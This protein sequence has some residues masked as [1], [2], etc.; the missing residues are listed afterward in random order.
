[1]DIDFVG[2]FEKILF[3][4][5][6]AGFMGA[7]VSV[8]W[9]KP[10]FS[11]A[12]TYIIVGT[13]GAAYLTTPI[14]EFQGINISLEPAVALA[15]GIFSGALFGAFLNMIRS[16]IV[17]NMLRDFIYHRYIGGVENQ[18]KGSRHRGGDDE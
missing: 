9:H 10:I 4:K 2:L 13:L 14:I 5:L 3:S 16:G 6:F 7:V 17:G 18:R 1:M 8:L 11:V 12:A 15:I